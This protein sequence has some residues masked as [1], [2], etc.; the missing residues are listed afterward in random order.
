MINDRGVLLDLRLVDSAIE[1]DERV[2]NELMVTLQ[3]LTNLENPN[4]VKQL[5]TWLK[6]NGVKTQSLGKKMFKN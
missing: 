3:T 5:S 6:D 4:S 1:L 2:R